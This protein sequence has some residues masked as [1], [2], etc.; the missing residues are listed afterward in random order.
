MVIYLYGCKF[1]NTDGLSQLPLKAPPGLERSTEAA[2]FHL[3]QIQALP[4]TATKLACCSRQDRH[5][6]KVMLFTQQGWPTTV[7]SDLQQFSDRRHELTVEGNCLLWGA[8]IV[9]P[10]KLQ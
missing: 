8:G 5:L 3:G 10:T 7:P 9:A 4:V 1:A 6:S 2:V